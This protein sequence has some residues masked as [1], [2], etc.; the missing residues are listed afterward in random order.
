MQ[1]EMKRFQEAW[2]VPWQCL[3]IDRRFFPYEA[4]IE[5]RLAISFGPNE[6][7]DPSAGFV[8]MKVQEGPFVLGLHNVLVVNGSEL[9][10]MESWIDTFPAVQDESLA[11]IEQCARAHLSALTD[12]IYHLTCTDEPPLRIISDLKVSRRWNLEDFSPSTEWT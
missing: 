12:D 4:D 11:S 3:F 1:P 8:P 6:T 5:S 9:N 10:L 2:G 7:T